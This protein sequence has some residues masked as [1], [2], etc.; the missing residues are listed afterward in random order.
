MPIRK[1]LIPIATISLLL[2]TIPSYFYFLY[3]N[4][5]IMDNTLG[6]ILSMS[7]WAVG[8]WI[9]KRAEKSLQAKGFLDSISR[10]SNDFFRS[11]FWM[12]GI[13]FFS[14]YRKPIL[15]LAIGDLI[16]SSSILSII[17][18]FAFS[19]CN[20]F[21]LK[22]EKGTT[23][24][25]DAW[26]MVFYYGIL[27]A[28]FCLFVRLISWYSGAIWGWD[29][30][31]NSVLVGLIYGGL[32][33]YLVHLIEGTSDISA[34]SL[35]R[36]AQHRLVGGIVGGAWGLALSIVYLIIDSLEGD[37]I[38]L[39]A[40]YILATSTYIGG[41]LI[42][43]GSNNSI[44]TSQDSI[45]YKFILENLK[46]QGLNALLKT[47]FI[48]MT[49]SV[50]P[51][52]AVIAIPITAQNPKEGP[53]HLHAPS[54]EL[55]QLAKEFVPVFGIDSSDIFFPTSFNEVRYLILEEESGRSFSV[56]KDSI[57]PDIFDSPWKMFPTNTFSRSNLETSIL[58]A[59]SL[60]KCPKDWQVNRVR[61][62]KPDTLTV[63]ANFNQIGDYLKIT[64]TIP[65]EAN[66][67][68]NYHRGDGAISSIYF[69]SEY[70][71][72]KPIGFRTY[73]H[74]QFSEHDF[75]L[76]QDSF[77]SRNKMVPRI[78]ITKGS[79][80]TYAEEGEFR[81]V[82]GLP[83]ISY[84]EKAYANYFYINNIKL[85]TLN[86]CRSNFEKWIFRGD[87]YWGGSP[88]DRIF[89]CGSWLSKFPLISKLPLGNHSSKMATDPSS[90]F[91]K[92]RYFE[93]KNN[94]NH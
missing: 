90:A 54:N 40:T 6:A 13:V 38:Y 74:L 82:D 47:V 63:Y 21:F 46:P 14:F 71:S 11:F 64:Y 44:N 72:F 83:L 12:A 8:F 91:E 30:T 3:K 32:Y 24:G 75:E 48:V 5:Y 93:V 76:L 15:D 84:S 35:S 17:L 16:I 1:L 59:A 77:P 28:L 7:F 9:G 45:S 60:P 19:I 42:L 86:S 80:S 92:K 69:K 61:E 33:G 70:G 85:V 51:I 37:K 26:A 57:N 18:S 94:L 4:E 29:G 2:I 89:P 43:K 62:S 41:V 67:W 65:F 22:D 58:Y 53:I 36:T 39:C 68:K 20:Y 87:V 73:N 88:R 27:G 25:R 56:S 81:N 50:W 52:I 23:D 66:Y 10:F 55:I 79:H 34:E 49:S 78:W 31:Y